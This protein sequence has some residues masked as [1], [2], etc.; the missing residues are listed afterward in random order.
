MSNARRMR[1]EGCNKLVPRVA[2]NPKLLSTLCFDCT[3][4]YDPV[5]VT[6]YK[7][8]D[9]EKQALEKE[10]YE[11]KEK[12]FNIEQRLTRD[13]AIPEGQT[14]YSVHIIRQPW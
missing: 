1:C 10:R 7:L 13:A 2:Y 11:L 9:H 4:M 8:P 3:E 5:T 12:L 6:H 14:S